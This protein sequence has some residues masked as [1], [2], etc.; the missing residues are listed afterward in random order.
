MAKYILPKQG[1]GIYD[2]T[3][4]HRV[5]ILTVYTYYFWLII[6]LD[7]EKICNIIMFFRVLK[8]EFCLKLK[9]NL[10]KIRIGVFRDRV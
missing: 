3:W 6:S 5:A 1:H 9:D 7:G 2:L 8:L 4:L 10:I